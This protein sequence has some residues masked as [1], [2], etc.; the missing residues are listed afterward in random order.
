L[1]RGELLC[2]ENTAALLVSY[3]VSNWHIF[4]LF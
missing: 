1:C 4:W 3:I 2:N